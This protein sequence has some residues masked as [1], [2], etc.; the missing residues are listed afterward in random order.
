MLDDRVRSR[1]EDVFHATIVRETPVSGGCVADVRRVELGDGTCL[2]VKV[3]PIRQDLDVEAAMLRYLRERSALPVPEVH[4]GEPGLLALSWIDSGGALDAAAQEHAAE[5][6]ASLHAIAPDASDDPDVGGRHGFAWTT[7]IGP[8]EQPNAWR[9]SWC[10]FFAEERL[11]AMAQEARTAG[12]CPTEVV[13]RVERLAQRL[14]RFLPEPAAPSLLH[15][16]AWTGNILVAPGGG[17]IAGLIDPAISF[18]DPE[19]ELAFTTLF[20]TFGEPFFRRYRELRP[21]FEPEG[22]FAQRRELY[23]LYPLL[24]H[25]R[26]FG[27]HYLHSV[28]ATLRRFGA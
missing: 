27:G 6:F 21:D 1:L 22:F 28:E 4:I 17:R 19:I 20:G 13:R 8:L 15:G 2:A 16:D 23:N 26:L 11:V 18:G 10:T 12:Q 9:S 7:R 24:V 5:L 25:V 14:D 3:D